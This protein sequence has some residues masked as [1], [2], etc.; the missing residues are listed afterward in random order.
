[1]DGRAPQA[2]I[3]SPDDRLNKLLQDRLRGPALESLPFCDRERV[4]TLLDKLP[5][6]SDDVR[7]DLDPVSMFLLSARCL[8]ERFKL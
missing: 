6:M 7:T 8:H 1:M 4:V 2:L 5:T 3:M